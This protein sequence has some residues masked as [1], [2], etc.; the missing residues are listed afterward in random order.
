MGNSLRRETADVFSMH[1]L[2][3][4]HLAQGESETWQNKTNAYCYF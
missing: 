2:I 4:F 1:D 3:S